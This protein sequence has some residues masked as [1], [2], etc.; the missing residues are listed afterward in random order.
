M[1]VK[2]A[3]LCGK[4]YGVSVTQSPDPK[5]TASAFS[6]SLMAFTALCSSQLTSILAVDGFPPM[7]VVPIKNWRL[8]LNTIIIIQS[9]A[10][11]HQTTSGMGYPMILRV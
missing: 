3:N 9:F 5:L 11:I 1:R 7:G 4:V 8:C 2:S 10:D 6:A